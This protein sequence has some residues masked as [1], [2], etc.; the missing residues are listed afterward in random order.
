MGPFQL[1]FPPKHC[2]EY[3]LIS[4]CSLRSTKTGHIYIKKAPFNGASQTFGVM[5]PQTPPLDPSPCLTVKF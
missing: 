3:F 2:L 1:R 5:L 4:V